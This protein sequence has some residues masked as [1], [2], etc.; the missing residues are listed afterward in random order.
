[1]TFEMLN[2][3]QNVETIKISGKMLEEIYFKIL[4][5]NLYLVVW[6]EPSLPGECPGRSTTARWVVN[7]RD[8]MRQSVWTIYRKTERQQ[9]AC[10][11]D[12][13]RQPS[14]LLPIPWIN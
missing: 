8:S 10:F 4:F 2:W 7:L 13:L 12:I 14:S 6:E 5:Q 3:F 11:S 1:M 9:S